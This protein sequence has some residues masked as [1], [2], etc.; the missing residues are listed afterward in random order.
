MR[1]IKYEVDFELFLL[2][3]SVKTPPLAYPPKLSLRLALTFLS[4]ERE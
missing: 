3:V 2:L 1:P 4:A